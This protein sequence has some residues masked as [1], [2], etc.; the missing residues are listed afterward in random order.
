MTMSFRLADPALARGIRAGDQ[1]TFAFEE[2][3][4][5]AVVRRLS[6]AAAR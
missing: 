5:G 1:V 2:T 4:G 6:P 3:P